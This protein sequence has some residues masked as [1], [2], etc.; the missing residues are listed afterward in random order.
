MSSHTSLSFFAAF[1]IELS[2]KYITET[3]CS[4]ISW[5]VR[6]LFLTLSSFSLS[7][8]SSSWM[9]VD[10]RKDRHHFKVQAHS[11][12]SFYCLFQMSSV[13][14]I[15]KIVDMFWWY[16]NSRHRFL[17]RP[18]EFFFQLAWLNCSLSFSTHKNMVPRKKLVVCVDLNKIIPHWLNTTQVNIML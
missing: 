17:I 2:I 5:D 8:S 14:S 4:E 18:R 1:S 3:S 10:V 15:F 7:S 11:C 12:R 16:P 13:I 6:W 9:F